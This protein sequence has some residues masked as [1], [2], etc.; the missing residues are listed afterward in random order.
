[1]GPLAVHVGADGLAIEH[2]LQVAYH[3]HVEDV[4][5]QVVVVAHHHGREIH[6][7]QVAL[8]NLLVGDVIEF[9]GGE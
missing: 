1:M 4:D 3:I 5:G 7:L 8:Q 2:F 6:H 9:R